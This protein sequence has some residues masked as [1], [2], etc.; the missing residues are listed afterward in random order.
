M[1]LGGGLIMMMMDSLFLLISN[2]LG[3]ECGARGGP[4]MMVN[5]SVF[6]LISNV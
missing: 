3:R 1:G 4:L 6:L 2:A 5:D